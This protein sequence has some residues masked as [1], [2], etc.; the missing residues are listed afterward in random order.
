MAPRFEP[1]AGLRY[2]PSIPLEKVIAPP[3]D[4]V[5]AEERAVLAGRHLANA[6]HVELPV[7]DPRTGLDR[8][9]SAA[10]YM[11]RWLEEGVLQRDGKPAF[12]AYRM[13]EA[14]GASS[15]GV[16]GALVCDPGG[17]DILPHEQTLPK[18]KSDRLDLLRAT[19]ANLS[20]IWGLS[21]TA[22][23]SK[24]F[25]PTG[26]PTA[27]ATDDE[28][29]GHTLWVLDDPAVLDAI[30][31]AVAESPVVIADGH[32]RYQTAL[33]YQKER[34][35]A[36][37]DV[38]GDYDAVMALVVELSE[39]QLSVGPIHRTLS[40]IP[41]GLDL[42][43]TFGR[44]FDTVHVGPLEESLVDAV[45]DSEAL[46]LV[47]AGGVWLLT[48]REETYTAAGSDLDSSLIALVVEEIPGAQIAYQHDWHSAIDAVN[49]G[50][51]DAAVLIR[52]VT[53]T[54]I[55]EWAHAHRRMPPKSTY[56]HPKPRTGMVYR[57]VEG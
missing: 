18:P 55:G 53:V 9:Q 2:D 22:G 16:I 44:W 15:T 51:V 40:G 30:S 13:T 50:D 49:T 45:A 8:Y 42:A 3:Y 46:A 35:A 4:I 20:P 27:Q 5:D 17:S 47:T 7:E 25:E 21:L 1:F 56:F 38:A 24:T 6:I 32:H 54:Q 10:R 28:G 12:Y 37:G 26:A 43:E 39:E 41:E 34:R 19:R 48:P 36:V 31:A 57:P 33:T 29:V 23:L 52:P 14:S 11:A